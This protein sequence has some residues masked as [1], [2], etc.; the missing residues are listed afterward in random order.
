VLWH[1]ESIRHG[2]YI[3]NDVGREEIPRLIE[4]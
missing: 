2:F 4:M 3:A 1:D